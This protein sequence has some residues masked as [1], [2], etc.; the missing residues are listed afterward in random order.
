M[1]VAV[2]LPPQ[3]ATVMMISARANT[4]V[5]GCRR[6]NVRWRVSERIINEQVMSNTT[7]RIIAEF[8]TKKI[9][10]R[11]RWGLVPLLVGPEPFP[12]LRFERPASR[13]SGAKLRL[14]IAG[15]VDAGGKICVPLVVVV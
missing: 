12:P 14:T 2:L 1:M 6:H 15:G 8:E 7:K 3:P 5:A 4:A 11:V 10:G 9:A 13:A